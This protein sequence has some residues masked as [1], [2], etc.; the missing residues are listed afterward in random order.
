MLELGKSVSEKLKIGWIVF[1]NGE[2][3]AGKTTL[4]KGILQGMGHQGIVTSP[5]YTLVEPYDFDHK[6]VYHFDLY[7]LENPYDLEMLGVRDMVNASSLC[8]IEWPEKGEGVFANPD[9]EIFIGY[10][11]KGRQIEITS[12]HC[13]IEL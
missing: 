4:V 2:L 9:V 5:T 11:D 12:P 8:L 1:L 7:R 10:A 13:S 6:K 3:G